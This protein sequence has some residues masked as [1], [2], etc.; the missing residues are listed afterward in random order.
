MLEQKENVLPE[1]NISSSVS[2]SS[3]SALNSN[4]GGHSIGSGLKMSLELHPHRILRFGENEN[5]VFL[6]RDDDTARAQ[7][8]EKLQ[9][10]PMS[11]D[12]WLALLRHPPSYDA[13]LF[14]KVRLFRRATTLLSKEKC[15]HLKSYVE[16]W[17]LFAKL[18]ENEK[19]TRDTFKYIKSERIGEREPLFYEEYAAFEYQ[20]GNHMEADEVLSLGVRNGVFSTQEK[21]A[22]L[23]RLAAGL[24]ISSPGSSTSSHQQSLLHTP[25]HKSA[26]SIART[27][28][29]T[30]TTSSSLAMTP[31]TTSTSSING[32]ATTRK[33]PRPNA[34][35]AGLK[36]PSVPTRPPTT[37]QTTS[38][39]ATATSRFFNL[40]GPPLRVVASTASPDESGSSSGSSAGLTTRRGSSRADE[41]PEDDDDD[42]G[43][44]MTGDV[45]QS[46]LS[47][48]REATSETSGHVVEND[49]NC[50]IKWRA[51]TRVNWNPRPIS[52][53]TATSNGTSKAPTLDHRNPDLY[54]SPKRQ[55]LDPNHSQMRSDLSP[56]SVSSMSSTSSPRL[57]ADGIPRDPFASL[58]SKVVVNG[59]TYIKL[60]QIGSGGSSKVYRMLGPDLKIYALK[61]IK[62]KRL[63]QSTVDQY[64]NEIQL[65]K[66]LQGNPF[67]IRLIAAERDL[68]LRTINVLMEHGEIDL[69]ERLREMK[70]GLDENFLRVIWTQ[71]LNAVDAIHRERIIHGDLKPANF[72]FV[73]GALKLID[74]GIAKAISNDTTNIERDSQ[75]GTVNFMSPEAIQGNAGPS[76]PRHPQGKMKG[77]ASER[78]LVAR[79]RC[80][81]DPSYPIPFPPL[82][83]KELEDVIRQCLQRD[84]RARPTI[85]GANGL[86]SH[87]FLR[88]ST[89]S[90]PVVSVV[91]APS[92]LQQM[93]DLLR[94]QGVESRDVEKFLAIG[95][96]GIALAAERQSRTTTT[97]MSSLEELGVGSGSSSLLGVGGYGNNGMSA[98]NVFRPAPDVYRYDTQERRTDI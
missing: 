19:E 13:K 7:L 30:T 33:L 56:V 63:D 15:R 24:S 54:P 79:F 82:K 10:D 26:S 86:L 59:L 74:F 12:R 66:R 95:Q 39:K 25:H 93:G 80:I 52:A 5:D 57:S 65:L 64:T 73:N 81:I 84:H 87:P 75:V 43:M 51:S 55:H 32:F 38:R 47:P 94:A 44:G 20:N 88:S 83:N 92:V 61:K 18:K 34:E 6:L 8:V 1:N 4:N 76:G 40:G 31:N 60:E 96:R 91:N 71:M 90:G 50:I 27:P 28:S 22:K 45:A 53:I 2:S 41:A 68:Q 29:T 42:D 11:P 37:A 49:R 9:A 21:Q 62:L 70:D 85:G 16:I 17:I 77:R 69:G 67:I 89:S 72:L 46:R 58:T 14:S 3:S 48:I 23:E 35:A 98:G 78:H 97:T 36:T